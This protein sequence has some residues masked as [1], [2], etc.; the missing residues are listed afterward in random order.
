MEH[1]EKEISEILKFVE[2]TYNLFGMKFKFYVSTRPE[3][4]IGEQET[5]DQAEEILK[6]CV[7]DAT[8][9]TKLNIKEGDGAFYG[10]KIDIALFDSKGR[11]NQCG[12]VQLDFNLPSKERFNLLYTDKDQQRKT[13]IIIHRAILGSLER[14]IGIIL[15]H[16]QGKLPLWLSPRQVGIT[17]VNKEF[18]PFALRI[19]NAIKS[20]LPD[21]QVDFDPDTTE[22]LRNQIKTLEKLKCN[23]IITVGKDELENESVTMRVGK[24]RMNMSIPDFLERLNDMMGE[25]KM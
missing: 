14:F 3:K 17:T 11:E 5:W 8:G 24:Q 1:I 21:V 25:Y 16:T 19:K 10:P 18:N 4:F 22:D 15:E 13:P 20:K 23:I 7:K 2:H 6:K 9:K 12:T